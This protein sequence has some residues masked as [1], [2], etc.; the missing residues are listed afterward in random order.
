[1]F[2]HLEKRTKFQI[3]NT[4]FF[5]LFKDQQSKKKT[6]GIMFECAAESEDSAQTNQPKFESER[7]ERN[8][9]RD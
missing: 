3:L 1:M 2:K 8:K 5:F 4:A 6:I 7:F 9:P